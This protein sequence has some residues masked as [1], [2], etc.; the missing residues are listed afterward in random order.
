MYSVTVGR[1][2]HK[3]K[4]KFE[5][6]PGPERTHHSLPRNARLRVHSSCNNYLSIVLLLKQL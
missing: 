3:R 2:Y 6:K 5:Y 4:C 1:N